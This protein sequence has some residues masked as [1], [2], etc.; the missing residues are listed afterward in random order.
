MRTGSELL[1]EDEIVGQW[2]AELVPVD[3]PLEIVAPKKHRRAKSE[4]DRPATSQQQHAGIRTPTLTK[5]A[6]SSAGG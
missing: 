3:A 1:P 5:S 6:S 4:I 2:R